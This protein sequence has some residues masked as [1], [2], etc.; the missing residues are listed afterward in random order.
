MAWP[1]SLLHPPQLRASTGLSCSSHISCIT[2]PSQPSSLTPESCEFL[3]LLPRISFPSCSFCWFLLN[4]WIS[5]SILAFHSWLFLLPMQ[6]TCYNPLMFPYHITLS[7][8]C[9]HH[10][11]K[12]P[13]CPLAY[14]LSS[15]VECQL[16][17]GRHC[18]CLVYHCIPCPVSVDFF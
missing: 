12:C 6:V 1:H 9:A 3:F 5:F 4:F 18:V 16:Q 14:C 2:F 11:Q 17:E 7:S 10:N 8:F 15:L 13:V